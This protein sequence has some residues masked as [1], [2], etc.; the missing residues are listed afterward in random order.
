M[1]GHVYSCCVLF[2]PEWS[3]QVKY[4]I[5]IRFFFILKL[6]VLDVNNSMGMSF[7]VLKLN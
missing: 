7:V 3:I 6:H 5:N 2:I 4:N 1:G